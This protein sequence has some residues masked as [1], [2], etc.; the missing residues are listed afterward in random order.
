MIELGKIQTLTMVKK[1]EFGVYLADT[2]EKGTDRY[3]EILLPQKEVPH[4]LELM[5]PI[6]VFVYRDSKDRMIATVKRPLIE[7]GKTATL[8]VKD[9]SDFGAFLDWG[10]EKDLFLPFK[11][12]IGRPQVGD[13]VSVRLYVDKSN[14]LSASMWISNEDKK[15]S[16]YEKNARVLKDILKKEGGFL[17]LNDKSDPELIKKYTGM[18]KNEFKKAV[19]NLYKQRIIDFADNGIKMNK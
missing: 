14:R 8:K 5:D 2:A 17:P 11:E 3:E 12:Q 9:I 1:V 6:Q 13:E 19:G 4:D 15:H 7:L 16:V 18:S 10:L